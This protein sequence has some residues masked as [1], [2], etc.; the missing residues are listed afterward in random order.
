MPFCSSYC[1]ST[2]CLLTRK[3]YDQF[4]RKSRKTMI[5]AWFWGF[6]KIF[7]ETKA[8]FENRALWVSRYYID[9]PSCKNSS[10]FAKIMT[11]GFIFR[12]L[13]PALWI[14]VCVFPTPPCWTIDKKVI[15]FVLYHLAFSFKMSGTFSS[16][17]II[18]YIS[19]QQLT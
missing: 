5:L 19:Q 15:K 13:F 14:E 12:D 11:L 7:G 6:L 4:L 3:S 16:Y 9:L 10:S 18:K 2:L 8:K 17:E 1:P